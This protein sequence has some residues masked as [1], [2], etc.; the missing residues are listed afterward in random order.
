MQLSGFL[1]VGLEFVFCNRRDMNVSNKVLTSYRAG[2]SNILLVGPVL[3]L[4]S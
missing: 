2:G 4:L 1:V 3:F